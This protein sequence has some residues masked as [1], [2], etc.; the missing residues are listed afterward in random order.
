MSPSFEPSIPSIP[1]KRKIEN[2]KNLTIRNIAGQIIAD[3]KQGLCVS[4]IAA[5]S[6]INRKKC[7]IELICK[8]TFAF[9]RGSLMR[10]MFGSIGE[11]II[12]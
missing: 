1:I 9:S 8:T 3:N 7:L 12:K 2:V 10:I 11:D 6:V 5:S 4:T